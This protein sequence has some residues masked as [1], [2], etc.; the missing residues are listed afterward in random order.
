MLPTVTSFIPGL[1]AGAPFRVSIH[2]WQNPEVSRVLKDLKKGT[3]TVLFEARLFIDGRMTAYVP[4]T[5]ILV[6]AS[7]TI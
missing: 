5:I 2:C 6:K 7:L 1:R 3:D 4:P